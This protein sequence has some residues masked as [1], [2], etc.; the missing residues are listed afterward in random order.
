MQLVVKDLMVKTFGITY[1]M[2]FVV[3]DFN[4][5]IAFYYKGIE[6]GLH[7]II[8]NLDNVRNPYYLCNSHMPLSEVSTSMPKKYVN[9]PIS[10]ILNFYFKSKL[11]LHMPTSLSRANQVIN[12]DDYKQNPECLSSSHKVKNVHWKSKIQ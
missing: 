6:M 8:Q 11:T 5:P 12:L 7:P 9:Y 10:F 4:N 1:H 2:W 3:M